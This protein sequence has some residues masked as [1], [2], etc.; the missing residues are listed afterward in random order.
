[1]MAK[2]IELIYTKAPGNVRNRITGVVHDALFGATIDQDGFVRTLCGIKRKDFRLFEITNDA[3]T[4][5]N[6]K[7]PGHGN[8]QGHNDP[9]YEDD[10]T[11]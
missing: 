1:M 4:C 2:M 9:E 7:D 10:E 3:V 8:L 5:A 6:C 11:E